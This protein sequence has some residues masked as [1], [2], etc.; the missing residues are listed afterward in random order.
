MLCAHALHRFLRDEVKA[1]GYQRL[2]RLAKL[3]LLG[4]LDGATDISGD[5]RSCRRG[6]EEME[7]KKCSVGKREKK[8]SFKY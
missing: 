6:N 8:T 5:F 4:K 2:S 1:I 3:A 7:M